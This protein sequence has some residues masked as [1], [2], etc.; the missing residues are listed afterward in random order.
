MADNL[1]HRRLE[2]KV[3]A[4]IAKRTE[5]VMGGGLT[6]TMYRE[7]VGYVR[8]LNDALKLCEEIEQ[9]NQ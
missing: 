9:E 4:Q 2:A 1:F 6:E 5:Y 3:Q 8:G 7:E